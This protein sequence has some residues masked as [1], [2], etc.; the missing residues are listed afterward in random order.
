MRPVEQI[1]SEYILLKNNGAI[2]IAFSLDLKGEAVIPENMA[3]AL[4]LA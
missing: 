1:L 2:R 3:E 4:A